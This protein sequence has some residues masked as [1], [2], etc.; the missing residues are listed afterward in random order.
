MGL[1]VL[2]CAVIGS[3]VFCVTKPQIM[4]LIVGFAVK[5]LE[6]IMS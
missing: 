4:I 5:I 1:R 6:M 2:L 3:M